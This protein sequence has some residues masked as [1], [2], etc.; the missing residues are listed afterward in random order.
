MKR[1][2]VLAA[3]YCALSAIPARAGAQEPILVKM[4][5]VAPN[6][7]PWERLLK[8]IKKQIQEKSAGRIKM[9][10]FLGGVKGGEEALVRQC[11]QGSLQ[12]VGVTTAAAAQ[13]V[14]EL[15]LFE[16]PYLYDSYEQADAMLAAV[17][18]QVKE[19]LAAKGFVFYMWTENGW[20][21]MASKTKPIL[22]PSDL[23]GMKMRSQESKAHLS[24]WQAMGAEPVPIS[25]TEVL[26]ALQT[27]VVDGYDNTPLYSFAASWYQGVKHYTVTDHIFQPAVVIYNKKWF[28]AQPK[29]IQ[30]I[31]LADAEK[32]M[33]EGRKMIRKLNPMLMDNFK[34][35]GI[36]LHTLD[37]AQKAA[38][39]KASRPVWDKLRNAASP[40]GKALLDALLKAKNSK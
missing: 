28:D 30:E 4:G 15:D 34:A 19:I 14:P 31:L 6:D 3:A 12:M 22:K 23:K 21:G 24:S 26:T 25:V 29:D 40:A 5:T 10:L 33:T 1:V 36:Q 39:A 11:A 35:A 18:P 32:T 16:L 20:R 38:F 17:T 37:A 13:I 9:Q 7:T 8:N 27:G 2:W